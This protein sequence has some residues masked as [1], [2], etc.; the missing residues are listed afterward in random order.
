MYTSQC[1]DTLETERHVPYD[2]EDFLEAQ[3]IPPSV[4][5]VKTQIVVMY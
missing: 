4:E 5:I 3:Q 2:E 1:N